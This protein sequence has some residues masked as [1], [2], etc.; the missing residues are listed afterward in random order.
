MQIAIKVAGVNRPDPGP[1]RCDKAFVSQE[2]KK[3]KHWLH[4]F[5]SN[6]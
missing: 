3:M 5:Y 1:N 2:I 6:S 4:L